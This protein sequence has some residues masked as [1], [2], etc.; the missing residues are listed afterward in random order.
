[1]KKK[2]TKKPFDVTNKNKIFSGDDSR[3]MWSDINNAESVDDLKRALYFV[4]CSLQDLE[5]KL[6]SVFEFYNKMR[7]FFG[8]IK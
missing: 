6:T 7:K 4:C 5:S 3:E 8:N 2:N 1:M